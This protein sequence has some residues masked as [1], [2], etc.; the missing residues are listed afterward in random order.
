[1]DIKKAPTL[2]ENLRVCIHSI[3]Y[4]LVFVSRITQ[5]VYKYKYTIRYGK[6]NHGSFDMSIVELVTI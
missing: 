1:M 2:Y 5:I 4:S 6:T 3:V